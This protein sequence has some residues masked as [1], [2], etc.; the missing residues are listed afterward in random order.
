LPQI[1]LIVACDAQGE[2]LVSRLAQLGDQ[3][4]LV[5]VADLARTGTFTDRDKFIARREHGDTWGAMD[6][7]G[8]LSQ[9]GEAANLHRPD[10][11]ARCEYGV[12][13]AGRLSLP[14]HISADSDRRGL[15]IDCVPFAG[16]LFD[17]DNQVG[18]GRQWGTRHDANR[19]SRRQPPGTDLAS[20]HFA[21]DL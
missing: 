20:E 19:L 15:Q 17:R 10:D 7:N 12:S 6:G 5:A 9:F 21:R 3:H 2:R 16:G 11:P 1:G 8:V 18:S 13:P 14:E 4:G